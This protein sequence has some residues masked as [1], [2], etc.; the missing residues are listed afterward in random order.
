MDSNVQ[1]NCQGSACPKGWQLQASGVES[2]IRRL[3]IMSHESGGS[4]AGRWFPVGRE[5]GEWL[6]RREVRL[7]T[8]M[9]PAGNFHRQVGKRSRRGRIMRQ[10]PARPSRAIQKAHQGSR[11]HPLVNTMR[12]STDEARNPVHILN[13]MA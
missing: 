7:V 11:Q 2:G 1:S 3:R 6:G 4:V 10:Q 9:R 5:R 12:G 8:A 13:G